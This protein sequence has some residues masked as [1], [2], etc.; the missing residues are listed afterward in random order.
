MS[1]K[2]WNGEAF[3]KEATFVEFERP[4]VFAETQQKG[5]NEPVRISVCGAYH[6][7]CPCPAD[8]KP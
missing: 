2:W 4:L 8:R 7:E 3:L 5:G 6:E 1:G